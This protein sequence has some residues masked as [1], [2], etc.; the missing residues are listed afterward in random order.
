MSEEELVEFIMDILDGRPN[1]RQQ[2]G[3]RLAQTQEVQLPDDTKALNSIAEA[4]DA[5]QA[6]AGDQ[7]DHVWSRAV[8]SRAWGVGVGG[9]PTW[10]S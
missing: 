8:A 2:I 9:V 1:V 6:F 5:A 4:V 3:E 7:A 10:D